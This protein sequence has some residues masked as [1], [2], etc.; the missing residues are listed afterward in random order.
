MQ[1]NPI[2]AAAKWTSPLAETDAAPSGVPAG[3]PSA[4]SA[5]K[6]AAVINFSPKAPIRRGAH[7]DPTPVPTARHTGRHG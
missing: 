2:P 5:L 1:V 7:L 3:K 4:G 6:A